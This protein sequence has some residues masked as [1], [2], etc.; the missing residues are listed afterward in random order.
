[1]VMKVFN[2]SA[3]MAYAGWA[4]AGADNTHG[5]SAAVT[6]AEVVE[7]TAIER[8]VI[9]EPLAIRSAEIVESVVVTPSAVQEDA[10]DKAE[11]KADLKR[12]WKIADEAVMTG[13][14]SENVYRD[15]VTRVKAELRDLGEDLGE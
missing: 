9:A 1:M 10:N 15:I 7:S 2:E 3:A 6:V 5:Q 11:R 12:Q 8:G 14:I 4:S 13:R